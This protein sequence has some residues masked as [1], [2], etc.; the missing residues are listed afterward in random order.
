MKNTTLIPSSPFDKKV[1][2][3]NKET[4]TFYEYKQG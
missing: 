2:L 1:P 4:F 3:L